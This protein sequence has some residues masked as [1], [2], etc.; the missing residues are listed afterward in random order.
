MLKATMK[1]CINQILKLL[2]VRLRQ[3][4]ATQLKNIENKY[5][6]AL[7]ARIKHLIEHSISNSNSG[8]YEEAERNLLQAALLSPND[9]QIAPHLGRVRFLQSH[10]ADIVAQNQNKRVSEP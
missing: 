1:Y 10:S 5:D 7:E 3:Y 6:P 4:T 8:D 9:P 2:P